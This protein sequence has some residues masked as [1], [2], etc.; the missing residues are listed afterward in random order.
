MRTLKILKMK[1]G[2]PAPHLLIQTLRKKKENKLFWPQSSLKSKEVMGLEATW[3]GVKAFNHP[4]TV[5]L[6]F[7]RGFRLKPLLPFHSRALE[8]STRLQS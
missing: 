7:H 6:R 1:N 4:D 5:A 2:T 3:E 8:P